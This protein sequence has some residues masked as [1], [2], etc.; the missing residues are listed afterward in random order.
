MV[1][2]LE[3]REYKN[4]VA[5]V[6]ANPGYDNMHSTRPLKVLPARAYRKETILSRFRA[7]PAKPDMLNAGPQ[8]PCG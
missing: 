4:E 8:A 7:S 1:C 3:G 2:E 5:D 6:K